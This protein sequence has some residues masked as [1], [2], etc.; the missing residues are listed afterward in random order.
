MPR[1]SES[2]APRR[3]SGGGG[4]WFF[5][6]IIVAG[7]GAAFIFAGDQL[8]SML[9]ITG[10]SGSEGDEPSAPA[11]V[12]ANVVS[13]TPPSSALDTGPVKTDD[14]KPATPMKP[15]EPTKPALPEFKDQT[16][17]EKLLV[18]A[19]KHYKGFKWDAAR[20]AADRIVTL[21]A[22]PA[23]IARA[24]DIASG[25]VEVANLFQ[26]L[27]ERDELVRNYDT[28]PSLVKIVDSRGQTFDAV[29]ISGDSK[30]PTVVEQ[31]PVGYVRKMAASG[32]VSV[33]M[34]AKRDFIFTELTE[35]PTEVTPVDQKQV[36]ADKEREFSDKLAA[37]RNSAAA[38]D[39]LVWY[40]AA[41][42]AYRNRLDDKVTEMLDQ[43]LE[44][45]PFL[46][47]S[48]RE[49]K[50]AKLY[51]SLIFHLKNG[52]KR[53]A[54]IYMGIINRKYADTKQ[55]EQAKLYHAGKT[56]ELMALAANQSQQRKDE[57]ERRRQ[58]RLEKAKAAGDAEKTKKIEQET[59]V[60]EEEDVGAAMADMPANPDEASAQTEF[61]SG[62]AIYRKAIDMPATPARNKEYS[63]AAE[64]FTRAVAQYR[65]LCEK[66]PGN[67]SLQAKMVEANQLR[68]GC[69]KYKTAF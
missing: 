63:K 26:K 54:D 5:L 35:V 21:Q 22:K 38:T 3:R 6:L 1:P 25:A 43:A 62:L 13:K 29:P 31:D 27:D 50:A 48:V 49:D 55:G 17:A 30:S 36:R 61:E 9:G 40:Q 65:K 66:N 7:L 8:R 64:F 46:V 37:L 24:R 18:D 14:S 68:F 11:D 44:L 59:V 20:S 32:K 52:N 28:S 42:F 60:D 56:G 34:K 53:Q 67:E 33:M 2:S 58:A 4:G 69:M 47:S 41:E 23:T 39:A 45:D 51:S 57:A 15:V 10:K 16:T 19:E 12:T